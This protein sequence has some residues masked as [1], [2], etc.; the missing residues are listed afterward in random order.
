MGHFASFND[1]LAMGGHGSYVWASWGITIACVLMLVIYSRNQRK[2]T[3]NN[4]NRQQARLQQ[5]QQSQ[6]E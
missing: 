5:R 1:F 3:L 4:I 2:Q 6:S